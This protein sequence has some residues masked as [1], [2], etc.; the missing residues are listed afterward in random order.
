MLHSLCANHCQCSPALLARSFQKAR[1]SAFK[2]QKIAPWINCSALIESSVLWHCWLGGRKG[3]H[4]VQ[5]LEDGGGGHCLVRMEWRPGGWSVSASVNLPLHRKVQKFSF[6]TGSCGWSRIKGRKTV[7]VVVESQNCAHYMM[8]LRRIRGFKTSALVSF[9]Q[10]FLVQLVCFVAY[11]RLLECAV[12][13][14]MWLV[15]W[16]KHRKQTMMAFFRKGWRQNLRR[17]RGS[18]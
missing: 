4:P 7:V 3:I 2:V 11:L 8:D 9:L 1:C 14:K 16:Q 6:G 5:K 12:D 10:C 18:G 17:H 15:K 13:A